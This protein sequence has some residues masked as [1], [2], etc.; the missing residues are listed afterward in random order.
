MKRSLAAAAAVIVAVAAANAQEVSSTNDPGQIERRIRERAL[1]QPPTG[2]DITGPREPAVPAAPAPLSLVLAGVAISGTSVFTP[3]DFIPAYEKFLS[4]EISTAEVELILARI[5]R[6]YRDKGYFLTTAVAPPQD[7]IGG[8]L[9][10]QIIEGY[11]EAVTFQN[12]AREKELRPYVRRI[13]EERPLTLATLERGVLLMND[14]PGVRTAASIRPKDAEAG[15]YELIIEAEENTA[16]G[17][18]F[19]NNWGRTQLARCKPGCRAGSTRCSAWASG[20]MSASSPCPI[21][22]RSCSTARSA[23]PSRWTTTAPSRR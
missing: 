10:V 11:V 12:V 23:T 15:A 2:A 19:F 17:S 14:V 4:R 20:C 22:R 6:L 7:V 21:S 16:D 5:T 8:I 9:R 1:P 3:A 13:V 18:F